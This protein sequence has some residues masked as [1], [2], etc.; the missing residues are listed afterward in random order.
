MTILV[1]PQGQEW[2][3]SSRL[4]GALC[5]PNHLSLK[6]KTGSFTLAAWGRSLWVCVSP[7]CFG[8]G[9]VFGVNAWAEGPALSPALGSHALNAAFVPCL[10]GEE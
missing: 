7:P 8:G 4:N 3:V 6:L 5:L 9:P 10:P 1:L 2:E